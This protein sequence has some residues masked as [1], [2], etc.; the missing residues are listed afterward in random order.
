MMRKY[1]FI[2]AMIFII[3]FAVNS[4]NHARVSLQPTAPAEYIL[5]TW[6]LADGVPGEYLWSIEGEPR[7]GYT[8]TLYKSLASP[9]MRERISRFPPGTR[10]TWNFVTSGRP[11]SLPPE[12]FE[13]F[14][15]FCASRNIKF[16]RQVELF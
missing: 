10:L 3:S 13:D 6:Q 2:P 11:N 7:Q 1:L 5:K 14:R 9:A 8:G 12:D 16:S 15:R 4:L